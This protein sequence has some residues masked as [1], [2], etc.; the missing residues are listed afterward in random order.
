MA[1][2]SVGARPRRR[3]PKR[4]RISTPFPAAASPSASLWC[5]WPADY[6]AEGRPRNGVGLR[7]EDDIR[8]CR[9]VWAGARLDACPA[10]LR[11]ASSSSCQS[12]SC[13][14]VRRG[15]SITASTQSG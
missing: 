5:G 11:S 4:S 15:Q 3:Q 2:G 7:L 13:V 10:E 9:E 14:S 8:V 6:V 1:P 12:S